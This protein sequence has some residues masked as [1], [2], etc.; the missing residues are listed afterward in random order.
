MCGIAGLIHRGKSSN[1]GSELQGMLQALKHRGEDST[2]YALYGDTDGKN[3]IMRFKVGENVGEGSSS[4]MED[5]SVYDE[6]IKIV[7]AKL[8]E[9]GASIVKEE[10]ILPYSLR[11]E[12]TYNAKDLRD[13]SQKI[14]SVPGVEILSLGKSLEVIKDLGNAKE[15]C[16]RYSLGNLVGTHAIGHARMATES[17][18]DIKSAHPFWGYPF[19]DVSVVHNGQLTNY[20][21]NRRVLENKGMRFMS[22]CDSE[23]IA[24]F[25]ADKMR[26]GAS[27]EEGMKDSLTELDGVFTYFVATKDSLGM[28]K[29]TMAAKPLVLYE[30]DDLVA[31]GSEEIAIRSVLPHEIDTY[32][33]F[34]GEVKVW[35]I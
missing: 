35:Q 28:A 4:V 5:V 1:V 10:R 19:S 30:S 14:E 26:N 25:L 16:D 2:G 33:P 18:V 23:L 17:G 9:L 15:V 34:N 27:L 11:Y 8:K 32:D 6:R 7:N 12:I 13:L 20:W 29:D 3:F 31:M 24:V 22:E 21:N